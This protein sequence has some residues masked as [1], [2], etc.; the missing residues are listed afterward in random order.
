V[1]ADESAPPSRPAGAELARLYD[2]D[3]DDHVVDVDLY[4]AFA[5]TSD[6]PILELACGSGRIS[7]PLVGDGHEVVGVDRDVDM[8]ERARRS[9]LAD[10]GQGQLKLVEGDI[11]QLDL[12][13]SFGLVVLALNSLL[14]LPGRDAQL[15][16]MQTIARHLTADGRAVIDVV[17]P[18]PDDLAAYDGRLEM[19][20]LRRDDERGQ[21]VAKLW[22][23]RYEPAS[24]VASVTTLFD[25]WPDDGGPV[26]RVSRTD[27]MHLLG[28]HELVA[29]AERAGLRPATVAGDHEMSSFAPD[30]SRIVLVAALL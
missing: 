17:L 23:A 29:L 16:A 22:S 5:R 2:L 21:M 4:L 8:L 15:A 18:S 3:M 9:W 25:C 14:M 30:S 11:T 24:A 7:V 19:A 6:G 10:G 1:A 13:R 26:R 27:E 28:A 12:G 20:W